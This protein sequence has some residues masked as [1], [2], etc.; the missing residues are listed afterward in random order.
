ML[1][2]TIKSSKTTATTCCLI[3]KKNSNPL[4]QIDQVLVEKLE[5]KF[6]KVFYV[7]LILSNNEVELKLRVRL[8]GDF[9]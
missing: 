8:L 3:P 5:E 7:D 2:R 1:N 6:D 4:F 9:L